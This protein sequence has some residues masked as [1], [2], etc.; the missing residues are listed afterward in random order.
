M[1][2]FIWNFS[3]FLMVLEYNFVDF[4]TLRQRIKNLDRCVVN[5]S[6]L[7]RQ[8]VA[9]SWT[10]SCAVV[11]HTY[12]KC[13][14]DTRRCDDCD[15]DLTLRHSTLRTSW[16]NYW[17]HRELSSCEKE[18]TTTIRW[19]STNSRF[20]RRQIVGH[21]PSTANSDYQQKSFTI[22][23]NFLLSK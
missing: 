5:F 19:K 4:W 17:R 10:E 7:D 1:R 12:I 13:N 21:R 16:L 18:Q 6:S 9:G 3:G 2:W 11:E 20:K 23:I 15:E 8:F 14:P 22:E